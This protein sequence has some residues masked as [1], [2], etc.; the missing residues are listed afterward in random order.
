MNDISQFETYK[1]Q[2][3]RYLLWNVT[4]AQTCEWKV[5]RSRTQNTEQVV[6]T[7]LKNATRDV[8]SEYIKQEKIIQREQ[9]NNRFIRFN[10]FRSYPTYMT[11]VYQ[12]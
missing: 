8:Y 10:Y 5:E 7:I 1:I 9:K 2:D 12:R 3:T 6:I 4:Y 11:S